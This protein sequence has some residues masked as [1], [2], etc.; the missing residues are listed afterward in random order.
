MFEAA[1][2]RLGA[3]A[4]R[5]SRKS[6]QFAQRV[7][8]GSSLGTGSEVGSPTTMRL[9]AARSR[10]FARREILERIKGSIRGPLLAESGRPRANPAR[11]PRAGLCRLPVTGNPVDRRFFR[12]ST[13]Q[14]VATAKS[15]P[16]HK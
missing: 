15:M 4:R 10:A 12:K 2:H 14:T 16:V 6:T 13:G 11:Y 9:L 5:R 7:N 1:A 8:P 3:S